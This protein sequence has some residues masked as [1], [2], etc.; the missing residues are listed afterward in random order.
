MEA[1]YATR[2]EKHYKETLPSLRQFF[3][4]ATKDQL[5]R[6]SQADSQQKIE[7]VSLE[8]FCIAAYF[9][10][11]RDPRD[12]VLLDKINELQKKIIDKYKIII[13][14][15]SIPE[16]NIHTEA[17]YIECLNKFNELLFTTYHK[18]STFDAVQKCFNRS[19]SDMMCTLLAEK[20]NPI[21]YLCLAVT[22]PNFPYFNCPP[23]EDIPETRD[24]L[25]MAASLGNINAT[26][27]L[28]LASN[29][30]AKQIQY[31]TQAADNGHIGALVQ[32]G[33]LYKSKG[34][35]DKAIHYLKMA[36][37]KASDKAPI[38]QA[39]SELYMNLAEDWKSKVQDLE[40]PGKS[41]IL[42]KRLSTSQLWNSGM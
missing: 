8:V 4:M 29:D 18:H 20:G 32:A 27:Y 7:S 26:Y 2:F 16:L 13:G 35:P 24:H 12:I 15:K 33:F 36:F 38:A 11:S 22:S 6:I 25:E 41:S 9:E 28:G 31:I 34:E 39:L 3:D 21:A 5:R 1:A 17:S 42:S 23:L 19:F 10:K 30:P 40:Q 37:E 14:F